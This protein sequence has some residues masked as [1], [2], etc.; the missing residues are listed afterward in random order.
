[1]SDKVHFVREIVDNWQ[2]ESGTNAEEK[3]LNAIARIKNYLEQ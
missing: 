1:M 2:D 3:L